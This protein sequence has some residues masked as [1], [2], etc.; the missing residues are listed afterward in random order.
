MPLLTN[1]TKLDLG[2][3][4]DADERETMIKI[5][6][7]SMSFNMASEQLNNLKEYFI[8]IV[9][10]NLFYKE[11]KALQDVSFEIKKGD[12]FGIVGTNGSGKSTLLKIVAGVLEPTKGK[13]EINGSIAPLIEL[14]AGFD[15]DLS[16]R[17]NIY[18]NGALLGYD[19]DFIDRHFDAIVEFAEVEKFL[20]M[21][22]KNYSSGMVARIA[23]AIATVMVPEILIVDE[24]LSVGDFMFQKKCED[25]ILDL[26]EH[27]N[28]TVLIV[29]HSNE[30]VARLCNKAIWIEK[31]KTRMVG[32]AQEVC[33]IY[34]LV[35]GRVGTLDAE[36][37]IIEMDKKTSGHETSDIEFSTT[38]GSYADISL[39]LAC[40]VEN[41]DIDTI[42][43]CPHLTQAGQAVANAVAGAY[44]APLL[45]INPASIEKSVLGWIETKRPKRI[46]VVDQGESDSYRELLDYEFSFDCE[47]VEL[48]GPLNCGKFSTSIYDQLIDKGFSL[49]KPY[50]GHVSDTATI[51]LIAAPSSYGEV[52]PIIVLEDSNLDNF[53]EIINWLKN[54]NVDSLSILNNDALTQAVEQLRE[55]NIEAQLVYSEDDASDHI[56]KARALVS[57]DSVGEVVV[58]T[59][60]YSDWPSGGSVGYYCKENEG[61]CLV[62]DDS[63]LDS[64]A[65][66]IKFIEDF[67]VQRIAFIKGA[68]SLSPSTEDLLARS[69]ANN[70]SS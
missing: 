70:L 67:N 31:G 16:A 69:V 56:S 26:I 47:I 64:I 62:V 41:K 28:T 23:F 39:S 66:A 30:Q 68:G 34:G 1:N 5:D 58:C 19:K 54:H 35:G 4:F 38:G 22:M 2:N 53:E 36:S 49:G 46:V 44:G 3:S 8:S 25:R 33:E 9:R 60:A 63:S 7:V 17:E 42:C 6:N 24:V 13:V 21:P 32:D 20:D 15:M 12:V 57:E 43:L 40:N 27:H 55:A 14:G 61:A 65:S 29:S 18:L 45:T 52:R 50:L 48:T 51:D 11:L 59:N 10:H 37:T